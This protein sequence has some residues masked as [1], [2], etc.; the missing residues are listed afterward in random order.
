MAKIKITFVYLL[1]TIAL[2]KILKAYHET[3]GQIILR[4]AGPQFI[5][6]P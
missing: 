5:I 1:C 3:Q 4:E 6:G 2:K